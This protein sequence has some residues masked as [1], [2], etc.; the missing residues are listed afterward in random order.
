MEKKPLIGISILAVVL[1][2]L[3]STSNAMGHTLN[4][5]N[6]HNDVNL[7]AENDPINKKEITQVATVE[8]DC[9][10]EEAPR[11]GFPVLCVLLYPLY[12]IGH[13][14]SEIPFG[15]HYFFYALML[16]IGGALNCFWASTFYESLIID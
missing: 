11:W 8:C 13:I 15:Y 4:H 9:E 3:G 12:I 2:M 14:L 1:L 7:I 6:R 5:K 10:N 16:D